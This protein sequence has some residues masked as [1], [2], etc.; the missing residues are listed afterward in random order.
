MNNR[1]LKNN[2]FSFGEFV[3]W[4][5]VVEDRKD[6]EKLGRLRVRIYGYH[7]ADTGKMPKDDLFWAMPMQPIIS[8]AMSGIGFSPT[9]IVEGTTVV[10]FFADG[11]FAQHPIVIGTLGGKPQENQLNGDGFKDPN[12]KYPKYPKGEQ[13]TNRLARNENISET[14]VQQKKDSVETADVAFGGTWKEPETPYAAKYPYNHVR[15][16]ES[17]HIEEFDDTEGAE[18]IHRYH[19]KGTFEEVHPDGTVVHKV[20]KDQYEVV[21]GDDYLLIKGDCKVNI[22]G[23]SSVLINGDSDIEINGDCKETIHGDY[24]LTV[25]GDWNIEVGGDQ[26]SDTSGTEKRTASLILLN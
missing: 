10:G 2:A 12:G 24:K 7:T 11:H 6:P 19:R 21:M 5:G 4:I 8:S 17:G 9:G 26:T 1:Q 22:V 13:D 20:V 14:I 23:N 16:S 15:E 25:D 3:W 18:R